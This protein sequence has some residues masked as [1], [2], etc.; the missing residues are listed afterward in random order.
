MKNK[1]LKNKTLKNK[2]LKNKTQKGG[3][4]LKL[5][6]NRKGNRKLSQNSKRKNAR[7]TAYKR[8]IPDID[9]QGAEED[10]AEV[11]TTR[12]SRLYEYSG[13]YKYVYLYKDDTY[14]YVT[15]T[16]QKMIDEGI[17]NKYLQDEL[18]LTQIEHA[19]F[20]TYILDAYEI[21][22]ED[23]SKIIKKYNI[24]GKEIFT[25]KKLVAT[26]VGYDSPGIFDFIVE[27]IESLAEDTPI[28]FV[29]LDIKPE[30]IGLVDGSY[31]YFDNGISSFYPVPP[32]FKEYFKL[33]SLILAICK[34]RKPLTVKELEKLSDYLTGDDIRTTF[35]RVLSSEEEERI[36]IY[37]QE[38]LISNG[39]TESEK[40]LKRTRLRYPYELMTIHCVLDLK[41]D[42]G[43]EGRFERFIELAQEMRLGS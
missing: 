13:S 5:H 33:A 35:E 31:M 2:A 14:A 38:F 21:T 19:M 41:Q 27:S 25:Y 40:Y 26:P 23:E 3:A 22:P 24:F 20:P 39:L 4:A 6:E 18:R 42:V 30:N 43:H 7:K 8:N 12:T 37:V 9:L 34:L 28:C 10:P 16:K 1:T 11:Q 29:N 32:E 15:S 17:N 36:K